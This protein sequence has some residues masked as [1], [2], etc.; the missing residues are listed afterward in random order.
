MFDLGMSAL[1][2]ATRMAQDYISKAEQLALEDVQ[3][4]QNY[5]RA[6]QVAIIGLETEYDQILVQAEICELDQ[7]EQVKK[8]HER[9][10]EYLTVDKLR[11]ELLKAVAGLDECSKALQKDAHRFLQ[12]P[13]I[14]SNRRTA[15]TDF[16]TL[17]QQLV[18]YLKDLDGRGLAYR[19]A[20]TGVAQ[21]SLHAI[22]DHLNQR[23]PFD[24]SSTRDFSLLINSI[25]QDRTKDHLLDS[26][27][28][29]ER[30]INRLLLAFR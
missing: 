30:I 25:Q 1:K 27:E 10:R 11:P 4:C 6:A 24:Q 2:E 12:W 18:Q 19:P 3:C 15:V 13:W 17:L 23:K 5:L 26:T 29:I 14:R 16:A 9:I 22:L 28:Q 8:L 21:A 20:G 7:L